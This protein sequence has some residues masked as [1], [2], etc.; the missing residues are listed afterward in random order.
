[1]LF[2]SLCFF[3]C[4]SFLTVSLFSFYLLFLSFFCLWSLFLLF[5]L[6]FSTTLT[7]SFSSCSHVHFFLEG[8]FGCLFFVTP[9]V[10]FPFT[11]PFDSLGLRELSTVLC[12]LWLSV[13]PV[14]CE[15]FSR[16]SFLSQC[17]L[18]LCTCSSPSI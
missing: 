2:R 10:P 18:P 13:F 5:S 4:F 6:S 7:L 15:F 16:A 12:L 8:Y 3:I 1:M 9:L 14:C 11:L 17:P